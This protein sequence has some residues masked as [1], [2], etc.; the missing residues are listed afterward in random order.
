MFLIRP[1]Q[2]WMKGAADW[3]EERTGVGALIMP[4]M[5][6]LV[7]KNSSWWYV[8]G[9]ATLFAFLL[10]VVTGVALTFAYVP[11]SGQAYESLKFITYDSSIGHILRGIHYYGASAMFLMV[12]LHMI[13]TFLF[14]SY[15][16]PREVSWMSGSVLLLATLVMGFTGQTLR[17]DQDAIWSVVV[18]AEQA[19]RVPF[20]GPA[21]TRFMLAGETLGGA[22]LSRFFAM[23]VF[24][25]PAV[26]F[27]VLGLH[28][29]LV[30]RNG[31][32]EPPEPDKRV[33]RATYKQEYEALL[34]RNGVPFWPDAAW[35]DVIFSV[36]MI[37]VVVVLAG[38]HGPR[39]LGKPPDPTIIQAS[40]VPDWYLL[41]YFAILA[42]MPHGTEP[43]LMV[44]FPVLAILILFFLPIFS[45]GGE[46]HWKRRPWAVVSVALT[47]VF[48]VSFWVMAY[49]KPWVPEFDA[50]PLPPAVVGE[51]SGDAA[52]GAQLFHDKMCESCHKIG[53]YGGIRGPD[54]SWVGERLDAGQLLW[55]ITNGGYNM[56]AYGSDLSGAELDELVAFLRTRVRHPKP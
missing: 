54:L 15:K 2:R 20:I 53:G 38:L 21:L 14:A 17:W 8:F 12:G 44:A 41:W 56:P 33:D 5:R 39:E 24:I 32:S 40:P 22:T 50:P 28:L 42:L 48:V 7:P 37:V 36:A 25:F 51:V 46:R 31:I 35:R 34:Q 49:R 10:Q 55:R 1:L 26:I 9:S 30:L 23:H 3:L 13:R 16:Y 52:I 45:R 4:A 18:G 43:Y 11:S 29:W 6:H 27:G 47:T 19:G